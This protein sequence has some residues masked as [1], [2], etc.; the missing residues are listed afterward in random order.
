VRF[1]LKGNCKDANINVTPYYW[2]SEFKDV[3]ADSV[4]SASFNLEKVA[5]TAVLEKVVI[6][7]GTTD[8][9]DVTGK[10][11][12]KAFTNLVPGANVINL[13]LKTLGTT[14]KFNLRTTGLL[15]A[16]VG[17]KTKGVTDLQYSNTIQLSK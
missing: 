14:D 7:L 15:F 4:Y 2:M 13:D 16:R 6:Y 5:P 11:Y 17:V 3:Y 10:A 1:N 9:V 12:E 8:V